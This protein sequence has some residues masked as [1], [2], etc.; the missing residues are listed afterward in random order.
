MEFGPDSVAPTG[1]R[2]RRLRSALRNT[3]MWLPQARQGTPGSTRFAQ[4]AHR[5]LTTRTTCNSCGCQSSDP[6]TKNP[7]LL[8]LTT[9][10]CRRHLQSAKKDLQSTLSSQ[11]HPQSRNQC[12]L[13]PNIS[14]IWRQKEKTRE[15]SRPESRLVLAL[16]ITQPYGLG[17]LLSVTTRCLL[18]LPI[19]ER[20]HYGT[21]N[22][23]AVNLLQ[24]TR[25]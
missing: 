2:R 25:T 12:A 16:K 11:G 21:R 4:H 22:L 20:H 14:G 3:K 7:R 6:Y 9:K 13:T 1:A 15:R 5:L 8:Q 24:H 10:P 18:F 23:S 17:V 19:V